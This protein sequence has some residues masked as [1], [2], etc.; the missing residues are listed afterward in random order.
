MDLLQLKDVW[1]ILDPFTNF[2]DG[3]ASWKTVKP[4][5]QITTLLAGE[6]EQLFCTFEVRYTVGIPGLCQSASVVDM[7]CCLQV[8]PDGGHVSAQLHIPDTQP[9][10]WIFNVG[11]FRDLTIVVGRPVL[12]ELVWNVL[13][14]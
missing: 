2:I 8:L 10:D 7:I 4:A 5:E 6:L 11:N 1:K 3:Q 9:V 12:L 13:L 14:R